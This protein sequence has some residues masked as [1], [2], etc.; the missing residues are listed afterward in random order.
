MPMV[1]DPSLGL[2]YGWDLGESGWKDGMD[3]N[4]KKLGAV[5]QLAVDNI[6]NAPVATSNGTRYIVGTSP[7]GDF[8]GHAGHVAARVEGVWLFF[9]PVAGWRA[10]NKTDKQ[11]YT[12][13]TSWAIQ[14]VLYQAQPFIEVSTPG[15]FAFDSSAWTK[16]PLSTV[17]TDTASA[18]DA[19]N[20]TD[21]VI[22]RDGMYQ[23]QGIVRPVRSGTNALPDSTAFAV[24]VGT[25]AADGD[26][27]AWGVSPDVAAAVF[28]L[29]V[30]VIRRFSMS[31]RVSLFA[32]HSAP[33]NVAL[34][35]ARLRVIRLT[36]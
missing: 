17:L 26:D 34:S 5:T 13:D 25:T 21:Y 15:S 8:A 35:R 6:V 11:I 16:V 28:T 12:F 20:N 24:G 22:P 9:V 23:V 32:K 4:L 19:A 2:A 30:N 3:L 10:Y 29:S 7:T 1:N 33:T 14:Q 27:V 36:D 18:W 31:D